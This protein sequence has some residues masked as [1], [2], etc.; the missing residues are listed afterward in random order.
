M[1]PPTPVNSI[2]L[3]QTVVP[4][5]RKP[6]LEALEERTGGRLRVLTGDAYFDS[7]IRLHAT[8]RTRV[9]GNTYLFGRRLLWQR[10]TVAPATHADLVI[11][12]L[13]PRILSTWLVLVLRRLLGRPTVLWGHAFSRRGA[14]AQRGRLRHAMRR[15]SS[16]LLVYTET[17][18]RDLR[19]LM[20]G[21][22]VKAA[23]NALYSLTQRAGL[24]PR[25][26]RTTTDIVFVG[27]LVDDKQP[28]LLLDAFLLALDDLPV[29]TRLLFVGDGP[30]RPRLEAVAAK[31]RAHHRVCFEGSCFDVAKLEAIYASAIASVS[32]GPV[33]LALIQSLWFGV[34]CVLPRDVTHGPEIEAAVEGAN[35]VSFTP[36]SV[37]SLRE[38]ITAAAR[39]RDVWRSRRA[40]IADECASRYSVDAMVDAMLS[41]AEVVTK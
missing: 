35:S 22:H 36:G 25:A 37:E 16:G 12:E 21:A 40:G 17:E 6:F 14:T 19:R 10:G 3:L 20:P 8:S 7:T 5:Y 34:P 15:L 30:M 24:L 11:A 13:N 32:P 26:D 41:M 9:V 27:R 1:K 31:S 38:A 39:E 4:A 18:A 28:Q 2:T 29:D 33:G 23:P